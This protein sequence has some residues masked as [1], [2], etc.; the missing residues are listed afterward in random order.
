MDHVG[1][2]PGTKMRDKAYELAKWMS[3]GVEGFKTY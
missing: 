1:I 2:A 3:F